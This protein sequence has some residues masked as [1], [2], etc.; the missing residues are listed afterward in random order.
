MCL[1]YLFLIFTFCTKQQSNFLQLENDAFV[2]KDDS[3][4]FLTHLATEHVEHTF[5]SGEEQVTKLELLRS[6]ADM[7]HKHLPYEEA[8]LHPGMRPYLNRSKYSRIG[9]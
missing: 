2:A 1:I 6:F 8:D 5:K 4:T 3:L 9:V 7:I